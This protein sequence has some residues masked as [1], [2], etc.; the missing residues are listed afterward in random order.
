MVADDELHL[1]CF[2]AGSARPGTLERLLPGELPADAARRKAR[3]PDFEVLVRLPSGMLLAMGSGSRGNRCTG[4]AVPL[5]AKGAIAGPPRAFDLEA[6]R[7]RLL[8]H[9][10]SPNIEGGCVVGEDLV[11][12][13]RANSR[14]RMNALVRISVATLESAIASGRWEA[15]DLRTT[16]VQLDSG[17]GVPLSFTDCAALPDGRIV[18]TSVAEDTRDS[19]ND[20]PCSAAAVGLLDLEGHVLALAPLEPTCKVE[21]VDARMEGGAIRLL[22][23]TDADDAQVPAELLEA[24]IA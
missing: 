1:G 16:E 5:D 23:V 24:R 14:D 17:D 8:D 18:F 12:L 19:Y 2:E 3:K 13:Q 6:L 7:S 22:M 15:G 11:L 9:F 20:G 4:V 21:G 10:A